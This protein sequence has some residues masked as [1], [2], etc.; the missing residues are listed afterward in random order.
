L[1]DKKFTHLFGYVIDIAYTM[2]WENNMFC[3]TISVYLDE[4]I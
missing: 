1:E 3:F 4:I 2:Y